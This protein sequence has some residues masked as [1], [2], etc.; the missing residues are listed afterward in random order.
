MPNTK[1]PELLKVLLMFSLHPLTLLFR[2][3]HMYDVRVDNLVTMQFVL[4]NWFPFPG[5]LR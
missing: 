3:F 4:W 2:C 1:L 5:A